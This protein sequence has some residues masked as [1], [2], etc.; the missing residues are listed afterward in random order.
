MALNSH[1]II[2]A[3]IKE[4]RESR[5][6]SMAELSDL[7]EVT[8]Q[9]ISQYEKGI[10]KPSVFTLKQLSNTL[11]FPF[12]FFYKPK[13]EKSC[14]NSPVFFRAVKSTPKKFRNAYSYYIEW[15]DEIYNYLNQYIKFPEVSLPDVSSYINGESLDFETIEE[16]ALKVRKYWELG[17]EP[18]N[19]LVELL[20]DKGI[21]L[22]RIKFK[23]KKIDAFSQWF[24]GKPYIF[25]GSEK[26]SAVRSRFDAAH[27]LGH[28]LLH[29][30]LK[31]DDVY[32]K[33]VSDRIEAEAH[34]FAG[35]LLMP[36]TSFP[37]EVIHNSIDYLLMLK[38]K[39]KTSVSAMIMRSKQLNLFSENQINYLN[40][41]MT[42]RQMWRREPLDDIIEPEEPKLLNEAVDLVLKNK[43]ITSDQ[44]LNDISLFQNEII[45]ICCLSD[46]IFDPPKKEH[47][48]ELKVIK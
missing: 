42:T 39:W 35:A 21:I 12:S 29:P 22:C 47:K 19:N 20:E 24:N 37:K 10:I 34:Y 36:I 7:I 38:E 15:A 31:I 26:G 25:L 44:F 23:N 17:D 45:N 32:R 40:R 41:Q 48:I 9:A 27:E 30:H 18:I 43:V 1:N 14:D 6:L 13:R 2:P 4:A 5:G 46:D 33:D 3:R 11:R 8:S 28:L 16:I